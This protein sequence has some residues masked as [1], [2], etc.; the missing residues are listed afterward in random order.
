MISKESI[1]KMGKLYKKAKEKGLI[2]E[3]EEALRDIPPEGKWHKD[4]EGNLVLD[5]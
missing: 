4:E 1:S 2:I 3:L 5:D